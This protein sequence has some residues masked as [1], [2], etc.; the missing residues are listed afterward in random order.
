MIKSKTVRTLP[1]LMLV[2]V[3]LSLTTA[4]TAG[5][6]LRIQIAEN[7]TVTG[8]TVTL[9]HVASFH[10]ETDPRVES[11]REL[12]VSSAPAPGNTHRFN[13]RFLNYKLGSA[14]RD[15][16]GDIILETPQILVIDRTAQV[17]TSAQMEELFRDHIIK[18]APWPQSDINMESI[19]V[20]DDL[21]LPEGA[22]RWELRENA[23]TDYL[24][25]VSATLTFYVDSRMIRR[26]PVSARVSITR[27]VLRAAKNIQRGNVIAKG[28][29]E[30]VQE[31]TIRRHGEALVNEKE[32]L[33]KQASRNIRAGTTLTSAM[34]DYPPVVERGNPVIILA[35]NDVLRITTR[36]EALEDGRL[37]ERVRVKNLQSGKEFSSTVTAPGWVTVK[38]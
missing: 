29:L 2:A 26:V 18:S 25:N 3:S 5:G 34:V 6:A 35:E 36:G 12:E 21:S 7:A 1:L 32:A 38:F 28:D 20:P 23:N 13:S 24:G 31:T 14:T 11:L 17:V 8:D 33:G 22:L 19:R 16:G 4:A 30:V 9:G 37:G 15:Q 27:E 10:P